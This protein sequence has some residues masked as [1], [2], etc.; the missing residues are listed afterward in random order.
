MRKK[1]MKDSLFFIVN[2]APLKK[3]IL[4]ERVGELF[5]GS[6]INDSVGKTKQDKTLKQLVVPRSFAITI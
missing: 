4:L 2:V 5:C 6:S 1:S 3:Q